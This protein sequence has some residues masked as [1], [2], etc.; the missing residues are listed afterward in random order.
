M[1]TVIGINLTN[2]YLDASHTDGRGGIF[3]K[4]LSS[5]HDPMVEATAIPSSHLI[6]LGMELYLNNVHH[7]MASYPSPSLMLLSERLGRYDEPIDFC[8]I[9]RWS[10]DLTFPSANP[11]QSK[12]AAGQM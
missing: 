11:S 4:F 5:S 6:L 1:T 7:I 9:E 2:C 8:G 12:S 10:F 3:W